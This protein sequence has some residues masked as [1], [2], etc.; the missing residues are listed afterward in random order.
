MRKKKALE[1]RNHSVDGI[2]GRGGRRMMGM[3]VEI[4]MAGCLRKKDIMRFSDSFVR[5]S[6][7][8]NALFRVP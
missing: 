6:E 8:E 7:F 2:S 3:V 1:V 5:G 4:G